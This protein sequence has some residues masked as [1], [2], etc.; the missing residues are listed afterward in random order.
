MASATQPKL[1]G[2]QE[3]KP[4]AGTPPRSTR[5]RQLHQQYKRAQI[6]TASPTQLIVLLYEGALRF[7][8]QAREA[9]LA[10]DLENQHTNLLKAQ[11]ILTELM[12][13]LDRKAGGD[14]AENLFSLYLFMFDQ[15]VHANLYDRVENINTVMK[16]LE[17]L[18]LSWLEVDR[19]TTQSAPAS[20]TQ[21]RLGDRNA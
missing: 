18:H 19:I 13:T 1:P 2:D 3:G 14:I 15:L 20:P 16:M 7:C 6:E 10:R 8:A 12:G 21:S 5:T 4:S 9:M 11:R 17:D